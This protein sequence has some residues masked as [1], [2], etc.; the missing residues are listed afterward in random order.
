[1]ANYTIPT[2]FLYLCCD[3]A[4]SIIYIGEFKIREEVKK[5]RNLGEDIMEEIATGL[6]FSAEQAKKNG[7]IDGIIC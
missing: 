6:V 1:M 3:H 5:R 2:I 4:H 7:L